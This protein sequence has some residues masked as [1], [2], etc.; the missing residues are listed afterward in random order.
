M[1]DSRVPTDQTRA[2]KIEKLYLDS[3]IALSGFRSDDK[4]PMLA[5]SKVRTEHHDNLYQLQF[6]HG[7]RCHT[8]NKAVTDI[9]SR[10]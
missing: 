3:K 9:C 10:V 8:Q 1:L 6:I 2:R 5:I 4:M 7:F